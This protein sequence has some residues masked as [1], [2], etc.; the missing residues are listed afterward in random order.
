M[1]KTTSTR[2]QCTISFAFQISLVQGYLYTIVFE[3]DE[4]VHIFSR[5]VQ[6]HDA[7]SILTEHIL[8]SST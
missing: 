3:L 2:G 4:G 6:Y 7:I 1:P 5:T 8:F